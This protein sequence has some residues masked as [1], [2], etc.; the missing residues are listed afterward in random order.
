MTPK[1]SVFNSVAVLAVAALM[2]ASSPVLA[3]YG[4]IG[5]LASLSQGAADP[6]APIPRF[7]DNSSPGNVFAINQTSCNL[8]FPFITNQSGFNTGIAIAN[9]TSDPFGTA[10]Q[11]GKVTLF[12][13]GGVAQ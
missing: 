1:M 7:C 5:P 3:Q 6:N 12:F 8:L 4:Y 10:T 2:A 9:T 13:Y 11:A